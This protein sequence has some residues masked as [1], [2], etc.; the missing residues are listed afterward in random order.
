MQTCPE[1]KGYKA[2]RCPICDVKVKIRQIFFTGIG[3]SNCSVCKGQGEINCPN[4]G[5]AGFVSI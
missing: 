4:C 1:C 2:V 5:G 3:A